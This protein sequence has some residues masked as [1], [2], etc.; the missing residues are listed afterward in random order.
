MLLVDAVTGAEIRRIVDDRVGGFASSAW[1]P[2]GGRIA[3]AGYSG[4]LDLESVWGAATGERLGSVSGQQ[5]APFGVAFS[6]DGRTFATI[7]G[8]GDTFLWD[9]RSFEAIG[10]PL[11]VADPAFDTGWSVA[12]SP[13]GRSLAA[14]YGHGKVALWD[15]DPESWAR[16][17][18]TIAGR[19]LT[20]AEWKQYLPG[21]P[22]HRTC[23]EWHSGV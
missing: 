10:P 13:D 2:D 19:N 12:Y 16:R 20:Q 9:A 21:L 17:A 15:V 18:C 5:L 4:L 3:T 11:H 1:S 14:T 7:A 22:Y 6:P 23:A 8:D